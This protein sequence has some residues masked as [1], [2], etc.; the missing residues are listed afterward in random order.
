MSFLI[1]ILFKKG[2]KL[3]QVFWKSLLEMLLTEDI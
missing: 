2:P 1:L 3:K